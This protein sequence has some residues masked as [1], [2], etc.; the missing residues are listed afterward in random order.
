MD[1]NEPFD[2]VSYPDVSH[3]TYPRCLFTAAPAPAQPPASRF[4]LSR[5]TAY[6]GK[7]C[8]LNRHSTKQHEDSNSRMTASTSTSFKKQKACLKTP[9]HPSLGSV[10]YEQTDLPARKAGDSSHSF[11][12]IWCSKRLGRDTAP[13]LERLTVQVQLSH[14]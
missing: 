12:T 3:W 8:G 13:P 6:V 4:A 5:N 14:L 7:H 2:C 11:E 10:G 9:H 1:V